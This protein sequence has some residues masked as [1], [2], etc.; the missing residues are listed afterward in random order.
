M[1]IIFGKGTFI[2]SGER[3]VISRILGKKLLG[4]SCKNWI[5]DAKYPT[6]PLGNQLVM[7]AYFLVHLVFDDISAYFPRHL[8]Q[9]FTRGRHKAWTFYSESQISVALPNTET[10]YI[11]NLTGLFLQTLKH[12]ESTG[13]GKAGFGMSHY[14]LTCF[15]WRGL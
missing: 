5:L 9:F 12:A 13:R 11:S 2:F 6:E 10:T 1:M 3:C 8:M 15:F 14:D 4:F 7:K